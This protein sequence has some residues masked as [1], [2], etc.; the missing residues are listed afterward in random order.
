MVPIDATITPD[1]KQRVLT[2][3]KDALC[4]GVSLVTGPMIRE[5]VD[6][7]RSIKAWDPS[8][9]IVPGGWHP[10]PLPKQT[11]EAPYLDY[12]VRGQGEFAFLELVQHIEAGAAPDLIPGIG[13]KRDGKLVMTQERPLRPL[14]EMAPKAYEIADFDAYERGCGCRWAMYTSSLAC[15]FNCSYCTN[16]GVYGRKWNA[17]PPGPTH[18]NVHSLLYAGRRK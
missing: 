11:L 3:V 8:F 4:P 9:P 6:I 12:I 2:E 7:A 10:S 17:L 18:I 14:V 5:T 15:P 1:F 16:S 13:F